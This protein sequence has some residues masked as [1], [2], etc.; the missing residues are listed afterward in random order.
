MAAGLPDLAVK[1]RLGLFAALRIFPARCHWSVIACDSLF[2][3][4]KTKK[5]RGHMNLCAPSSLSFFIVFKIN[6]RVR[7]KSQVHRSRRQPA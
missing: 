2:L 3:L 1:L 7:D 4:V 5:T 6:F